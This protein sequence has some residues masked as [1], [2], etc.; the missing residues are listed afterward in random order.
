MEN[1]VLTDE[2]INIILQAID[3][4]KRDP[5]YNLP[6]EV[7]TEEIVQSLVREQ[8]KSMVKRITEL[9]EEN[10]IL[11]NTYTTFPK[12]LSIIKA[13]KTN[14]ELII[15]VAGRSAS[16][17]TT[18]SRLIFERL[19]ML[20]INVVLN[21]IDNELRDVDDNFKYKKI[22]ALRAKGLTV[23]IHVHSLNRNSQGS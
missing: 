6:Q 4:I 13:S 19:N 22:E 17:K 1:Q 5:N 23:S 18:I 12:N 15:A 3:Q 7:S 9:E 8:I 14:P 10:R 11:K 20:G 21:D 2:D 16:G